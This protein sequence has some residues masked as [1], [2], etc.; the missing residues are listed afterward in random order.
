MFLWILLDIYNSLSEMFQIEVTC[1]CSNE[2]YTSNHLSIISELLTN[3]IWQRPLQAS[4]SGYK[5]PVDIKMK[6]A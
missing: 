6:F 1:A 4:S 2:I 3:S 5:G